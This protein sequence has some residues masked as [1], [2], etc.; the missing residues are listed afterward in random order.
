MTRETQVNEKTSLRRGRMLTNIQSSQY[1]ENV[2]AFKKYLNEK[3]TTTTKT[4]Q[5]TF[6]LKTYSTRRLFKQNILQAKHIAK[7]KAFFVVKP[8]YNFGLI[9]CH[10]LK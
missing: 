7:N 6:I 5:A 9:F 3:K 8:I 2:A 4:Y 1:L 10:L